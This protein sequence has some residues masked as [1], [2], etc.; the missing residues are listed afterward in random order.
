[1]ARNVG[2]A[3]GPEAGPAK[4]VLAV[5]GVSTSTVAAAIEAAVWPPTEFTVAMATP[6]PVADTS[7]ISPS[8]AIAAPGVAMATQDVPVHTYSVSVSKVRRTVPIGS[9]VGK[10]MAEATGPCQ[11]KS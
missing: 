8:R 7:P 9:D 11:W 4:N 5:A 2:T 10:L 6:G 1:M 3:A